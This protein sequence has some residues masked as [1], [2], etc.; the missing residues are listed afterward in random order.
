MAGD[1][2]F[3][4]NDNG[5]ILT[6]KTTNVWSGAVEDVIDLLQKIG[7]PLGLAAQ[8]LRTAA[9]FAARIAKWI[10]LKESAITLEYNEEPPASLRLASR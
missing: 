7:V 1:C 10:P 6:L 9:R 3:E 2:V 4:K 5:Y 8:P